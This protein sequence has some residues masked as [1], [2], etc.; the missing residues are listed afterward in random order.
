MLLHSSAPDNQIIASI[1]FIYHQCDMFQASSGDWRFLQ[2]DGSN[3]RGASNEN[4]CGRENWELH[5]GILFVFSP[6]T[7][8]STNNSS[9][10]LINPPLIKQIHNFITKKHLYFQQMFSFFILCV[11]IWLFFLSVY[12]LKPKSMCL[13]V[14]KLAFIYQQGRRYTY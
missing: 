9:T 3:T 1:T 7:A 2:V 14:S 13:E 11:L 10:Y 12:G 4:N 5:S 6:R 8:F